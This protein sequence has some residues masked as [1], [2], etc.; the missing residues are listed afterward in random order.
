[1]FRCVGVELNCNH[2]YIT[3][4]QNCPLTFFLRKKKTRS[5]LVQRGVW[6]PSI[7][8]QPGNI[9]WKFYRLWNFFKSWIFS[10]ISKS[11]KTI[12]YVFKHIRKNRGFPHQLNNPL[13][14]FCM[15]LLTI[16]TAWTWWWRRAGW[17]TG[18]TSP[19]TRSSQHKPVSQTKMVSQHEIFP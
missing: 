10:P 11:T 17:A 6:L 18:S 1:M 5:D 15:C 8:L 7:Q 13:K 16:R 4:V 19:S 2:C 12:L 3:V 14:I 9:F